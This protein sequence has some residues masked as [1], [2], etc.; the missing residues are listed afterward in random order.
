MNRAFNFAAGPAALPDEVLQ[1]AQ[2]ELMVYGDLGHSIMEMSHRSSTFIEVAEHSEATLRKLLGI[3]DDF[4][5]LFMHGG[6][7][8]QFALIPLNLATPDTSAEY[9]I[10][11]YWSKRACKEAQRIRTAHAVTETDT[12][13]AP[14][15]SWDR[16]DN[17][18]YLYFTSNETLRGVQFHEFPSPEH[19]PLVCD[20]TSDFLTRPVDVSNFGLIYA[21][22]QKNAGIAGVTIVIVRKELCTPLKSN[23]LH[24]L[25]YQTHAQYDSMYNTPST[26]AWY[27][28]GLYFDW[29]VKEGGVEV[30]QQRAAQKSEVLYRVIDGS[31]FYQSPVA[32]EHR[33][34]QNVTFYL[35]DE[36]QHHH[37]LKEASKANLKN[38]EGHREVGGIRASLYNAVTQEGVNTLCDFIQDF[39]NRH[40]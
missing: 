39:E 27:V 1:I 19:A 8:M 13:I 9:A 36:R 10:T 11:G 24:F 17:S 16:V 26:F 31:N 33:S 40:G 2:R 29:I 34:V 22:A 30:M 25:N 12:Y 6:A 32:K 28:S 4:H 7:T 21:G 20:M 38:L 37:F 14:E 23:E 18:S 35:P 15:S 5:V 3:N